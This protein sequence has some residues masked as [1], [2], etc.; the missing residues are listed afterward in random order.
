[1]SMSIMTRSLFTHVLHTNQYQMDIVHDL[2]PR[3]YDQTYTSSTDKWCTFA[4]ITSNVRYENGGKR[5]M[6]DQ[7]K[8]KML[9]EAILRLCVRIGGVV[10]P[11]GIVL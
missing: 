11:T 8:S 4:F 7:S 3:T 6:D 5:E 2:D 9:V 1:M 10:I